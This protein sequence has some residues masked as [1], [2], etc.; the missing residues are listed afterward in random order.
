VSLRTLFQ[1]WMDLGAKP[2]FKRHQAFRLA[3]I[4]AQAQAR[5]SAEMKALKD[6]PVA[7]L[8]SGPGKE[9]PGVPGWAA[10]PKP[11]SVTNDNR[12]V[13]IFGSPELLGLLHTLRA[14][15]APYPGALEA[16]SAAMQG[17]VAK[18]VLAPLVEP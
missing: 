8:K 2:R 1:K 18:P 6:D 14:L 15:L 3:V 16:V 13:N 4:Q 10:P 7:W 11:G 9:L 17:K 12:T 5:L